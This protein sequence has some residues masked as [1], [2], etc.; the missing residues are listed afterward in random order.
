M[1]NENK[2]YTW[3]HFIGNQLKNKLLFYSY[4]KRT[5]FYLLK[6]LSIAF[7]FGN[8]HYIVVIDSR[9]YP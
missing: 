9:R 2:T 4:L 6:C 3:Y 1:I 7:L 5:L 8:V